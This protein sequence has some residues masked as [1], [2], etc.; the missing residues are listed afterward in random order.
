MLLLALANTSEGGR[1][2]KAC[3]EVVD[4]LEDWRQKCIV[5]ELK[6][7]HFCWYI[8]GTYCHGE[9]KKNWEEKIRYCKECKV[10]KSMF[11][12]Y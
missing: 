1:E 12:G 6:I 9:Y 10:F 2:P 5:G 11:T 4:C 3:W 8:N 7:K